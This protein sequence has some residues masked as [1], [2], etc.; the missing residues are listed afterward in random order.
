MERIKIFSYGTTDS[1]DELE[2]KINR[3]L[4]ENENIEIIFR[5][6]TSVTG[7]NS[8]K[9]EFINLTITIFYK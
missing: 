2:Q 9:E 1:F 6:V 7:V 4:S 5:K 8:L 3:W